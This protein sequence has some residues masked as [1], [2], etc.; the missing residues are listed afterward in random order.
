MRSMG[1]EV[2]EKSLHPLSPSCPKVYPM[3]LLKLDLSIQ[4]IAA[5]SLSARCVRKQSHDRQQF[6]LA[7]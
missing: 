1:A 4:A 7:D 2:I 5:L 6:A 3:N